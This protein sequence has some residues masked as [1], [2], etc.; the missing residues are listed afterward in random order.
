MISEMNYETNILFTERKLLII[1][2]KK[3]VTNIFFLLLYYACS[4]VDRFHRQMNDALILHCSVSFYGIRYF[5]LPCVSINSLFVLICPCLLT[6]QVFFD[7]L[8][9]RHQVK[10]CLLREIF[11]KSSVSADPNGIT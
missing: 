11:T 2:F 4:I 5:S 7:D 3:T 6:V 1:F 9:V 8:T 10:I